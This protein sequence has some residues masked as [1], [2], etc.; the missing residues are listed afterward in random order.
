MIC[1]WEG[2]GPTCSTCVPSSL[3][4]FCNAT[5]GV[6]AKALQKTG[7]GSQLA[8]ACSEQPANTDAGIPPKPKTGK[9]VEVEED[10]DDEVE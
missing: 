4:E 8:R 2:L 3:G 9:T 10:G 7:I 6:E 1:F 5:A